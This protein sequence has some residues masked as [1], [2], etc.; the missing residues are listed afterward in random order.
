MALEASVPSEI[1]L[2]IIRETLPPRLDQEGRLAF[3]AVRSVCK[4][5]RLISFASP[6]LWSTLSVKVEFNGP[7]S[8]HFT[9]LDHW[10]SRSGSSIPLELEYED[11]RLDRDWVQSGIKD[12]MKALIRRHQTQWRYLSLNIESSCFWDIILDPPSTG[13]D[14]LHTLQLWSL[15]I[16]AFYSEKSSKIFNTLDNMASL[17]RLILEGA[18][19]VGPTKR[20]G[21]NS[22]TELHINIFIHFGSCHSCLLLSYANLTTLILAVPPDLVPLLSEDDHISL[23]ALLTFTHKASDFYLLRHFTTPK[24]VTLDICLHPVADGDKHTSFLS[25]FLTRC[26]GSLQSFLLSSH[27][28]PSLITCILPSLLNRASLKNVTFDLWPSVLDIGASLKDREKDWCPNL[29]VLS[30]GIRSSDAVELERMEALAKFLKRRE[31]WGR[32]ALETLIVQKGPAAIEFPYGPFETVR[33]GK[34]QVLVPW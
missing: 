34:L 33:L 16:E 2:E 14:N 10:F 6:S 32:T 18:F 5:W 15:D 17:R 3:Q 23:P 29:R 19:D 22:I 31:E 30:V 12:S 27:S 20:W 9:H 26:D 24:L 13:W 21:P 1:L 25:A 11:E 8:G 7:D 4:R 28:N